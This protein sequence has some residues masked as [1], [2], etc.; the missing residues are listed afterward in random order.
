M[1]MNKSLKPSCSQ[2]QQLNI[3]WTECRNNFPCWL[4][5]SLVLRTVPCNL[6]SWDLIKIIHSLPECKL[7]SR[8]QPLVLFFCW[9]AEWEADDFRAGEK[10][11]EGM[12]LLG[13]VT[14]HSG[15]DVP[16]RLFHSLLINHYSFLTSV[17]KQCD[18]SH[19]WHLTLSFFLSVSC[20]KC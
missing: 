17:I 10:S 15:A 4:I 12:S 6:I 16:R 3:R 18:G 14:S 2:L 13:I 11:S 8:E 5:C 19:L 20:W 7:S 9:R 1:L